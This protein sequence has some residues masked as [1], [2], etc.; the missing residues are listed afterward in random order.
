[1]AARLDRRR[2]GRKR[3]GR[4]ALVLFL[5]GAGAALI[6]T[7]SSGTLADWTQ[8]V[9]TNSINSA[10]TAKAVILR[11]VGGSTC[12]SSNNSTND[13]TCTTINKYGGTGTP[14]S[15]GS[16]QQVDVTFIIPAGA[17]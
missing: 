3:G 17:G 1:M 7:G 2:L 8:A 5:S 11:E 6:I 16:N 9:I 14:L 15:P 4:N 10:G 13:F 12:T